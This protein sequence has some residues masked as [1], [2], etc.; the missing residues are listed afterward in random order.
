MAHFILLSLHDMPCSS[1]G[2]SHSL[3]VTPV[4]LPV[5]DPEPISGL[6]VAK[7][8]GNTIAH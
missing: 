4:T 8:F 5:L 3:A 2:R 7:E 1:L 6:A